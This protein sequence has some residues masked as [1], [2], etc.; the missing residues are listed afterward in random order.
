[1]TNGF[2]EEIGAAGGSEGGDLYAPAVHDA[3]MDSRDS[4]RARPQDFGWLLTAAV[5]LA[6]AVWVLVLGV[7]AA[8]QADTPLGA[9]GSVVGTLL[10]VGVPAYW[11]LAGAW[12]RSVWGCAAPHDRPGGCAR[13]RPA[14]M[15]DAEA[16]ARTQQVLLDAGHEDLAWQLGDALKTGHGPHGGSRRR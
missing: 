3:L 14:A 12:R 4:L 6:G 2:V 11:L 15:S 16:V 5:F 8:I 9:L 13:H 10:F 7:E 1:L